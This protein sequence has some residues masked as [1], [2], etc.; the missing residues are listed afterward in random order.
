MSSKY[1]VEFDRQKALR[2]FTTVMKYHNYIRSIS[3]LGEVPQLVYIPLDIKWGSREHVN[4]LFYACHF[5]RG[6]IKSDTAFKKMCLIYY[7]NQRMFSPYH[8]VNMDYEQITQIFNQVG[9]Y[10]YNQAA[11]FW[12]NNSALLIKKYKGDIINAI[13]G[14]NTF[15]QVFENLRI[16]K[17]FGGS[18]KVVTLFLLFLQQI[19]WFPKTVLIPPAIDFHWLRISLCTE[20]ATIIPDSDFEGEVIHPLPAV[21]SL[22]EFVPRICGKHGLKHSLLYDS[23]W[24]LASTLCGRNP[25]NKLNGGGNYNN[26]YNCPLDN[27]CNLS[28]SSSHY[29]EKSEKIPM[30]LVPREKDPRL[31]ESVDGI[32]NQF[33]KAP[34]R[35]QVQLRLQQEAIHLS[36]EQLVFNFNGSYRQ[37]EFAL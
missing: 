32:N 30:I 36:G 7:L 9:L 23:L 14:I 10:N 3:K 8:I 28:L 5:M 6:P 25:D 24:R 22:M 37:G 21:K 2:V 34:T 1:T 31:L 20:Y 17:G 33:F 26:C 29:Y 12:K 18:G 15:E 27:C 16:F 19:G 13:S 11:K 35:R 4:F